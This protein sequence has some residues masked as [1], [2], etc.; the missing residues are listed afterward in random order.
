[1]ARELGMLCA[2][3]E[4]FLVG[5]YPVSWHP[6]RLVQH[7]KDVKPRDP[8]LQGQG[9]DDDQGQRGQQHDGKCRPDRGHRSGAPVIG[10]GDARASPGGCG[11]VHGF[12]GRKVPMRGVLGRDTHFYRG[13]RARSPAVRGIDGA[14]GQA[15]AEIPVRALPT[16]RLLIS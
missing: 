8:S 16:I 9:D 3:Y 1:M 13:K 12:P 2:G 6:P 5:S 15:K 10:R 4:G 14:R 7:V 11:V